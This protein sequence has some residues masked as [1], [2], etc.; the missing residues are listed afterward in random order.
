MSVALGRCECGFDFSRWTL[1]Y[2]HDQQGVCRDLPPHVT[3]ASNLTRYLSNLGLNFEKYRKTDPNRLTADE[4]KRAVRGR[5]GIIYFQHSWGDHGSHID[6]WT[7]NEF[8]NRVLGISTSDLF[9]EAR[10]EIW[11]TATP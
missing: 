10:G 11:F 3:N 7:G 6:Y 1:R 4:I 9:V 2:V 8:M 5:M